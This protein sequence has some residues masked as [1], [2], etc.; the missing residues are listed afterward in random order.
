MKLAWKKVMSF[1][2]GLM[3]AAAAFSGIPAAPASAAKLLLAEFETTNDSFTGRG[4]ASVQWTS[5]QSYTGECSLF[6]SERGATWHG[7]MRDASSLMRAGETYS[8]SAAVLQKSGEPVEMKFS[9]QYSD[10]GGT[11]AYSQIALDT[12]QDG[13]WLVLSNPAYQVPEGATN[14]AIYVETTESQTDF[15]L[16][17]VSVSGA[18]AVI[19][20]G[21]AN[22]D[23]KVDVA[24]AVSLSRF[25]RVES[26]E[27]EPGADYDGNG[28]INAVDLSMLKH[29]LLY[30]TVSPVIGDWDN[31][32][33]TASPAMLK[34]YQDGVYRVGNTARIREKIAKAQAG[35]KVTIGYIGGS[36][37]G[38]GS[39][40]SEPKRFVNLSYD[41]FKETFGQ[42]NNVSM[43][44]A[45]AAGTSSVVGNM[46]VDQ[47]IFSKNCDIIFIEFAVNDQDGDRFKK[48]YEALVKKCLMQENAP[49]VV[50]IT[51]CQKSGSSCQ[52]WMVKVGENYDLPVISGKNAIMN[53]IN[54]GTLSWDANYG[55]GDTIHPGDGGH[56]LI[57]DCI[58][59][60]YRQAL[61]SENASD[62]YEI[63]GKTVYGD[64]YATAHLVDISA[65]TNFSAGSWT[66]GTNSSTYG[67]GY[68]YS[69]NGNTPLSFT[70][71]G[72]GILLLFQSNS[73]N[74]GAVNVTVNGKTNKVTSNL[75]WTWGGMDGDLGYYQPN[76]DTLNISIS[77]ADSG[78]FVLYGIAVI[79]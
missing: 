16:D 58:A 11:A 71:Q 49:A 47:D 78:T 51:L 36:I 10:A 76:S 19:K 67:V 66:R 24:D 57:A 30:P 25:L 54:A 27:I 20:K 29:A 3:T 60:Y 73:S 42:G 12:A 32:Q 44:N 48:S 59:Y 75:Q 5:D 37:T 17:T 6:V 26:D 46:R 40:T 65:Q 69:K 35:E 4:G 53:A 34:V 62:S 77:S 23:L 7:A 38:G 31:Y 14:L 1:S 18:P 55:S 68:T 61:R 52:D 39:A 33:E 74:M 9:L 43:V 63:P 70:V 8:L 64:E 41:Y 2:L 45:G 13:E 21:D 56:Q 79:D 50:L 28:V 72:K 22:G 15:Y